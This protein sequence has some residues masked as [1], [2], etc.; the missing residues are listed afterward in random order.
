MRWRPSHEPRTH[1][2]TS[3]CHWDT[4]VRGGPFGGGG[5]AWAPCRWRVRLRRSSLRRPDRSCTEGSISSSFC[6]PTRG[7]EGGPPSAPRE[8]I[9]TWPQNAGVA[10]ARLSDSEPMLRCACAPHSAEPR[11]GA[12]TRRVDVGNARAV[13]RAH[14]PQQTANPQ[15]KLISHVVRHL[16]HRLA[17]RTAGAGTS[18][19]RNRTE[20]QCAVGHSGKH[21]SR[22]LSPVVLRR[23]YQSYVLRTRT[24]QL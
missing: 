24:S 4:C 22:Y 1:A 7:R 8:E 11:A 6:H 16:T 10:P 3:C 17:S 2:R 21:N 15:S 5:F 12:V 9:C 23:A 20:Q 19:C 14:A 18:F 13:R